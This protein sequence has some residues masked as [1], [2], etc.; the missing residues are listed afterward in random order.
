MP[1]SFPMGT[2]L[3]KVRSQTPLVHNI[4]NYVVMNFTANALLAIGALPIMAHAQEEIEEMVGIAQ[5]LVIN[6]GTLSAPWVESMIKAIEAAKRRKIPVILDP[7]GAGATNY[8]TQTCLRFLEELSPNIIRGNASEILALAGAVS[9]GTKGVDSSDTPEVALNMARNI[10]GRYG[11]TVCVSGAKDFIVQRS[12]TAKII[13]GHPWMSKVTGMGCAAT[14]LI[15]AFSAISQ[16]PFDATVSA[17]SVMGVA[18]D[19][20]ARDASGPGSFQVG[21]LD[22]LSELRADQLEK[23]TRVEIL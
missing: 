22:A 9:K 10:S 15:A 19:I 14:A 12:R 2:L 6:I 7:V 17:M 3:E 11:A 5:A 18:G 13:N 20:A 8:R 16:D 4:T 21:F 1:K 23:L